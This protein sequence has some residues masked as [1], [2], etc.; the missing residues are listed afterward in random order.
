MVNSAARIAYQPQVP[1]YSPE[2]TVADH[3]FRQDNPL[4]NIV[5]QYEQAAEAISKNHGREEEAALSAATE[6]MDARDAWET[7]ARIRSVL[8]E[9][10][11]KLK[12]ENGEWRTL[13]DL[14]E[15]EQ[16]RLASGIIAERV[17]GGQPN[18]EWIFGDVYELLDK[19]G[20]CRDANEFATI[21]N[22]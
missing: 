15:E 11:I 10:G 4:L 8:Q 7:E 22:A 18:A 9:L 6:L 5:R 13:R 16:K 12:K 1:F 3:I 19:G 21:L 20:E 17:N 2:E 14:T